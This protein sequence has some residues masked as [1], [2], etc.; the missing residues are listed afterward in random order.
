[1]FERC[2]VRTN[3]RIKERNKLL[4]EKRSW[5]TYYA[6]Y[7]RAGEGKRAQARRC[8]LSIDPADREMA[9]VVVRFRI[10]F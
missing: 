3:E 1:M 4:L 6:H 2:P 10:T 9:T 5:K 8:D 7:T